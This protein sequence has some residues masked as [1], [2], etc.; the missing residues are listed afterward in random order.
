M[1]FRLRLLL[2]R[3]RQ[4]WFILLLLACMISAIITDSYEESGHFNQLVN[5]LDFHLK[6]FSERF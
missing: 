3:S 4:H 5:L 1:L 6:D 2:R